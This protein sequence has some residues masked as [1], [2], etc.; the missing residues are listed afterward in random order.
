M[1]AVFRPTRSPAGRVNCLTQSRWK[2]RP[3][4][5]ESGTTS[6][7]WSGHDLPVSAGTVT[8][9][10]ARS[11]VTRNDIGYTSTCGDH[12]IPAPWAGTILCPRQQV[13]DS[14][15]TCR[16]APLDSRSVERSHE[17]SRHEP[18]R[19]G[20]ASAQ[21]DSHG[22]VD[23]QGK[24]QLTPHVQVPRPRRRAGG[25]RGLS[26]RSD[27]EDAQPPPSRRGAQSALP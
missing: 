21:G 23:S 6:R 9:S 4:W 10:S 25:L 1:A 8:R 11:V 18:P 16:Q 26:L 5:R 3:V 24:W 12:R 20:A 22:H 17:P 13:R 7:V 19:I 27:H 14:G 2:A 15:E